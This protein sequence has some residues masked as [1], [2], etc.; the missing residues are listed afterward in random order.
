MIQFTG[1]L[2]NLTSFWVLRAPRSQPKSLFYRCFRHFFP[3][4]KSFFLFS[5]EAR[6]VYHLFQNL[7]NRKWDFLR[8]L[9]K[10]IGESV[11]FKVLTSSQRGRVAANKMLVY[12][13]LWPRGRILII[14]IF[15]A[16]IF[17]LKVGP[18]RSS[19]ILLI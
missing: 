12:L 1:L 14:F 13:P 5:N 15:I 2:C 17:F 10:E 11:Y 19:F 9:K 3:F 8:S 6:Q 16:F 18:N 7:W 4:V